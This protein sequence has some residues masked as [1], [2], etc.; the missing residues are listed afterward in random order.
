MFKLTFLEFLPSRSKA[1]SRKSTESRHLWGP[2]NEPV[3]LARPRP[4][5]NA[6]PEVGGKDTTGLTGFSLSWVITSIDCSN[7]QVSF[8][9][10]FSLQRW[11]GSA[12]TS[13]MQLFMAGIRMINILDFRGKDGRVSMVPFC[14][15][16]RQVMTV[17]HMSHM[18]PLKF[19]RHF[20]GF[21]WIFDMFPL[22]DESGCKEGNKKHVFIVYNT[23][24]VFKF[25]YIYINIYIYLLS[26]EDLHRMKISRVSNL[27][28]SCFNCKST[29]LFDQNREI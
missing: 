19:S 22:A 21:L 23:V 13:C 10:F 28:V 18:T 27:Y 17:A 24:F 1:W 3:M 26:K 5:P 11:K 16:R 29:C 15:E 7:P 8:G 6:P 4:R 25:M 14:F 12:D 2:Q 9:K 20:Y